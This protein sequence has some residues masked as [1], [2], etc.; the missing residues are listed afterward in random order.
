MPVVLKIDSADF[1][2]AG[3][4]RMGNPSL[5]LSIGLR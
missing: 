5:P 4:A 1:V 2:E 3:L